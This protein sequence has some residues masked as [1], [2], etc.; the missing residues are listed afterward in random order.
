MTNEARRAA[1]VA[2]DNP[3]IETLA[4]VGYA[5]S[6]LIH[7]LI[8]WITAQIALGSKGEADQGGALEYIRD[9]PGG[10]LMLWIAVIGFA[11]LGLWQLLDAAVGSHGTDDKE[12]TASRLKALGK[13]VMYV[14]LA[15]TSLT[16]AKGGSKDSGKSSADFTKTVM[17]WPAGKWLIVLL[18]LAVVGVGG[19]HV[20]KGAT[21]KFLEDLEGNASGDLGRGVVMAG[22]AGYIA[23]GIAFLVV[24]GI[25]VVSALQ[26]DPK[27]ATGLDG[28]VKTMAEQPFGTVLLLVVAVGLAAYGVYSFARARYAKM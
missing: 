12:R 4:R 3:A 11:A 22:M 28:A 1:T 19:Y 16:F 21:K 5:V 14:A 24:G 13:G 9:A 15:A 26:S 7:L 8:G 20:Y 25:F 27:E 10:G 23:K 18:G 2:S 6:G 17:E